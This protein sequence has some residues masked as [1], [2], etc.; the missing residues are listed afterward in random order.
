MLAFIGLSK[1]NAQVGIGT[2]SPDPSAQLELQSTE[3]GFLPPRL[4]NAQRDDNIV[5]PA[6]GLLIYNTDVNCL[7]WYN[8]TGW[9]D[10]C[11]GGLTPGPLTDCSTSGFIQPFVTADETI[12]KDVTNPTTGK[13]WMD[14]NLGATTAARESDDCYAYGNLYQWGRNSDGHESRTSTTAAG[15]VA[16]GNEGSDFITASSDWLSTPDGDRWNANETSGG[17]VVKTVNDPCPSGYRI[18]TRAELDAERASWSSNNAAGAFASPLKL[19]MAGH[20]DRLNGSL[21]DVG[22]DGFYWSSTV[23]DT[24]ARRLFFS[25]S[26]ASMVAAF[27]RAFGF[28]VRCLKD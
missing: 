18:P 25:S 21:F 28:S 23:S 17:S 22:S 16:T 24:G 8:G 1:A 15:P 6:E 3:K 7:Q 27:V 26:V 20:R 2:T 14:R 13:I 11:E 5:N 4:T 10:S 19:P 12:V 9:F